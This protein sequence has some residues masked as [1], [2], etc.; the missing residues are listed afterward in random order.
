MPNN[1]SPAATITQQNG[2]AVVPAGYSAGGTIQ[3]QISNLIV[4]NIKAGANVG[5]VAGTF[6][7]DANAVAANIVEG[8]NSVCQWKQGN[9]NTHR[10]K[11]NR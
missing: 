6:T 3:A 11:T 9:R 7:S 4:A 5:G 2:Q 1:P 8:K 10:P